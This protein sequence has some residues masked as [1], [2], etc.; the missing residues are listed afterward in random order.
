[1]IRDIRVHYCY[2]NSQNF[3]SGWILCFCWLDHEEIQL[4]NCFYLIHQLSTNKWRVRRILE[5]IYTEY[6]QIHLAFYPLFGKLYMIKKWRFW[7]SKW[8]STIISCESLVCFVPTEWKWCYH[9]ISL[10]CREKTIQTGDKMCYFPGR[11]E[12]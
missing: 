12:N 5:A 11:E 10:H 2:R 7:D 1:M 6:I 8:K 9:N 3:I 4:E